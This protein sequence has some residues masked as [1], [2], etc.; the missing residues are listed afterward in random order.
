MG[1]ATLE[2]IERFAINAAGV[3]EPY[4]ISLLRAEGA[5]ADGSVPIVFVTDADTN[6]GIAAEIFGY[7]H[8]LGGASPAVIVG[9]GYGVSPAEMAQRRTVDLSPPVTA[10]NAET[11]GQLASLIG[12]ES[13]GATRFLDFILGDLTAEIARRCPEASTEG[14]MLLGHSLGGLFVGHA[15]LTRPQ[16]FSHFFMLSPAL[17][18]NDFAELRHVDA[19]RT[20]VAAMEQKPTVFVA[21]GALEQAVPEKLPPQIAALGMTL[22][23]MQE[24]IRKTRMVDAAREFAEMLRDAGVER[25]TYRAYDEEDHGSVIPGA[26]GRSLLLA[27]KPEN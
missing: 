16:A 10:E 15:L 17:W 3:D 2:R 4:S 5:F 26:I 23:A 6:F 18:W 12:N 25:C 19:F 11:I 7:L 8:G 13:G 27:L 20:T 1:N 21:V 14:N 22:E 9:I 24:M